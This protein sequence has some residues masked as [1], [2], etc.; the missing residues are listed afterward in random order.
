MPGNPT[1]M[2][3]HAITVHA[4]E[5]IWQLVQR[6]PVYPHRVSMS[7]DVNVKCCRNKVPQ[8]DEFELYHKNFKV[9]KANMQDMDYSEAMGGKQ[10]DRLVQTGDQTHNFLVVRQITYQPDHHS[11]YSL[12]TK[13]VNI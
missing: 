11:Q 13:D 9:E 8:N 12:L 5:K 4:Q 10:H 6:W 3:R 1:Q 2:A 7:S